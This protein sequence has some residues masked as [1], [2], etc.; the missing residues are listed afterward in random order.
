M[1]LIDAQEF[2][3]ECTSFPLRIISLPQRNHF[4]ITWHHMAQLRFHRRVH[5]RADLRVLLS[6]EVM[7]GGKNIRETVQCGSVSL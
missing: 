5:E 4:L 7:G 6:W 3:K 1:S 2:S